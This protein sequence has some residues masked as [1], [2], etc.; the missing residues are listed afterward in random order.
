MASRSEKYFAAR[1]RRPTFACA[2]PSLPLAD[3]PNA[4]AA[5][6]HLRAAEDALAKVMQANRGRPV[7]D[8]LRRAQGGV[9]DAIRILMKLL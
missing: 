8:V 3:Q 6:E 7:A 9:L 2:D 1:S 4:N 5:Q